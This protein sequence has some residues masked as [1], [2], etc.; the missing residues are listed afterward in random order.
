MPTYVYN[1]SSCD[2]TFEVDQRI[3]ENAL[4]DCHCGSKGTLKRIIQPIAVMFKGQGF[5]INDYAAKP[6]AESKSE[7]KTEPGP[8]TVPSTPTEAPACSGEPASCPVCAPTMAE[9]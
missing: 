1:C 9:K 4:T 2:K 5:H 7:P 8:E 6:T 3:T